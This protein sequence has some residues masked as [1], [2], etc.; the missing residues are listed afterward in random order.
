MEWQKIIMAAKLTALTMTTRLDCARSVASF[1][2]FLLVFRWWWTRRVHHTTRHTHTQCSTNDDYYVL[3][4]SVLCSS[5]SS[6][7]LCRCRRRRSFAKAISIYS[8]Q[9][10][11]LS[12]LF[13][14]YSWVF[15]FPF[16]RCLSALFAIR[17]G[18]WFST[19]FLR[20]ACCALYYLY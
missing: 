10:F 9:P 15:V 6:S 19:T 8:G 4:F 13:V 18:F 14:P 1:V 16:Q 20:L 2:Q 7:S 5:S 17:I 3:K 11:M 12:Q